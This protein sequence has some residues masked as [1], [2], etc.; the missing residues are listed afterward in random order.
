MYAIL[1]NE[2]WDI[3]QLIWVTKTDSSLVTSLVFLGSRKGMM[4]RRETTGRS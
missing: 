1:G 4:G 2:I 3:E